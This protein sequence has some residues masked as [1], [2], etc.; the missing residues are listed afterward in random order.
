MARARPSRRLGV[1]AL[2]LCAGM[3]G[4]EEKNEGG[5]GPRARPPSLGGLTTASSS[6]LSPRT[7]PPVVAQEVILPPPASTEAVPL[8][9][10]VAAA[11]PPPPQAE[12]PAPLPPPPQTEA[13]A[14]PP[15]L[16]PPPP[17]PPPASTTL[18]PTVLVLDVTTVPPSTTVA[19]AT[20][21]A[22]PTTTTPPATTSPTTPKP[23]AT[24]A[25]T[26]APSP[27][28]PP[29]LSALAAT[30]R[31]VG[32]AAWPFT[33][34]TARRL[35]AAVAESVD[36][37]SVR[38]V[39][40]SGAVSVGAVDGGAAPPPVAAAGVA[41][42]GEGT[43]RRRRLAS[44]RR[45]LLQAGADAGA[46]GADVMLSIRTGAAL[47][48]A[49]AGDDLGAAATG[50]ALRASL[51]AA[52]LPLDSV[53]LLSATPARPDGVYGCA[54]GAFG[55]QCIGGGSPS[56]GPAVPPAAWV[57]V[58]AGGLVL[59]AILYV[60]SRALLRRAAAAA[61]AAAGAVAGAATGAATGAT[62]EGGG[63]GGGAGPAGPAPPARAPPS[64]TV[65]VA[66]YWVDGGGNKE[67]NGGV[68]RLEAVGGRGGGV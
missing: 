2:V 49:Q 62:D 43:R 51:M 15:P 11:P 7:P 60:I 41:G 16:P 55:G 63:G 59:L 5:R 31:L 8:V 6:P 61:S 57:G 45:S 65:G 3:A 13:P 19:P 18:P 52:G 22:A 56:N 34:A 32:P 14:P 29:A 58:V 36:R 17:P 64:P 35:A 33:D 40:I 47:R 66:P 12:A 20:T 54:A 44:L 23:A 28:P 26:P 37:V 53:S 42:A 68:V 39:S 4:K 38:D 30:L 24:P 1:L 10:A 67:A 48:V 27:T 46:G 21:T 50:G 25:P 9:T